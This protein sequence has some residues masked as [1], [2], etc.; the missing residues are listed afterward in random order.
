MLAPTSLSLP[1]T[2]QSQQHVHLTLFEEE[3]KKQ[4]NWRKALLS[5]YTIWDLTELGGLRFI[6]TDRENVRMWWWTEVKCGGCWGGAWLIMWPSPQKGGLAWQLDC[7]ARLGQA[8]PCQGASGSRVDAHH[9]HCPR[10]SD[11]RLVS[12]PVGAEPV[13]G[14]GPGAAAGEKGAGHSRQAWRCWSGL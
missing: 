3:S 7:H 4:A 5:V 9:A 1:D 12:G 6:R 10:C 14:V 13:A 8:G 11:C 2:H